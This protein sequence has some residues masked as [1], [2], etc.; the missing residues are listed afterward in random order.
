MFVS[1]PGGGW[2]VVAIAETAVQKLLRRDSDS[3]SD[4]H[5]KRY[6]NWTLKKGLNL[7]EGPG[8]D[9]SPFH[10]QAEPSSRPRTQDRAELSV[11][12]VSVRQSHLLD[13]QDFHRR[14]VGEICEDGVRARVGGGSQEPVSR[15]LTES[16]SRSQADNLIKA[17]IFARDKQSPPSYRAEALLQLREIGPEMIFNFECSLLSGG[18]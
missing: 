2:P 10:L 8:I 15:L 3:P 11:A 5:R 9:G 7:Y 4:V 12:S 17:R 1:P 13:D 6:L 18:F 16:G 14:F